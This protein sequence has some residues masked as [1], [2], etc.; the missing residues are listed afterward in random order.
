MSTAIPHNELT[1][2]QQKEQ[3]FNEI[4]EKAPQ[5]K[6]STQEL[7]KKAEQAQVSAETSKQI[8]DLHREVK[9]ANEQLDLLTPRGD[10][11]HQDVERIEQ[12]L[13][14]LLAV[15]AAAESATVQAG[16]LGWVDK[17]IGW[18]DKWFKPMV[19]KINKSPATKN[20]LLSF[21]GFLGFRA[22]LEQYLG[23]PLAPEWQKD[24]ELIME[25]LKKNPR[26][27]FKEGDPQAKGEQLKKLHVLY[28]A[29][30]EKDRVLGFKDYIGAAM[31]SLNSSLTEVTLESLIVTA[32]TYNDAKKKEATV[33][34][35]APTP[36]PGMPPVA[37]TAKPGGTTPPSA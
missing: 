27:T 21:A 30:A 29:R 36:T 23:T 28:E 25:Q 8:A 4:R 35:A 19:E 7:A 15:G 26:L 5:W 31:G 16:P 34:A 32:G 11:L 6:E 17:L 1:P 10:A 9:S 14:S 22:G 37:P 20:F 13:N 24:M 33:I 12:Q 18:V 3:R 2:E